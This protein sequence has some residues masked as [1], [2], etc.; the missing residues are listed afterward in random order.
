VT[1]A[2][3]GADTNAPAMQV[4][5]KPNFQFRTRGTKYSIPA[6][7]PGSAKNGPG[8][9]LILREDQLEYM[10]AKKLADGKREREEQKMVKGLIAKGGEGGVSVGSWMD[11]DWIPDIMSASAGGKGRTVRVGGRDGDMPVIGYGRKNP[12]ERNRRK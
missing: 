2:A 11:P 12:N 8:E 7:K 6:P 1:I 4:H 5:L 3:P 9:G 10:R